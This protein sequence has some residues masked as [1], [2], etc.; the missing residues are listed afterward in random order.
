[1]EK[2]LG[3][4]ATGAANLFPLWLIIG[5]TTALVQ[6]SSL[7]WFKRDY[8]TKGLALTML[9][10]GTTLTLEVS[11]LHNHMHPANMR[12]L[13][14]LSAGP[15]MDSGSAFAGTAAIAYCSGPSLQWHSPS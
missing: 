2:Q 8:I 4:L 15:Y 3:K 1:M 13:S 7:T 11:Y 6:P 12:D 5:A 10:M 9:A 14:L